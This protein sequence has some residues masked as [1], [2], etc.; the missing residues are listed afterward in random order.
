MGLPLRFVPLLPLAAVAAVVLIGSAACNAQ[1]ATVLS[2]DASVD[3]GSGG[4]AGAVCLTDAEC[5]EDPAI[6]SLRGRCSPHSDESNGV[7]ICNPG[8]AQT[9]N[10][11]C[12]ESPRD[13]GPPSDDCI[14]KGG[15]CLE[16]T[17]PP[18]Y[19]PAEK[20][21]GTCSGD[22]V[23]A[24]CWVRVERAP[25]PVC[26]NDQ[27]CNGD[28]AASALWGKCFNGVCMCKS[29][30]TVQPNGKCHTPPPPD[31][32]TQKGTCRQQPAQCLGDELGSAQETERSCGDFV[33]A[34][35]CNKTISCSRPAQEAAGAGWFPI[36]FTCCSKAGGGKLPICVNGWQTCEA[37]D[38]PLAKPGICF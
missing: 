13:G 11:K 38:T 6:S 29:G 32:T 24:S 5:N 23:G 28:P 8:V 18:N 15:V 19:R 9:P 26:Y 12:G 3:S 14:A 17:P 36:D 35:C 16:S 22:H 34:T 2:S 25:V 10:G 27:G 20:G 1:L 4:G 21:E 31:C 30:Y 7:C 33:A 37:G